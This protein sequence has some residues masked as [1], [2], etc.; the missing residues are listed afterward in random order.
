MK[1]DIDKIIRDG[2][3]LP[4]GYPS[5]RQHVRLAQK[6]KKLGASI[7]HHAI[8]KWHQRQ[9]IQGQHMASLA[10]LAVEEHRKLDLTQYLIH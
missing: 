5:Q 9:N 10:E 8:S 4:P 7:T 3:G 2:A 1:L 6:L